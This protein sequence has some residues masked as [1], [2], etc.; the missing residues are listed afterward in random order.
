MNI[1]ET[2]SISYAY[3]KKDRP[4][5]SDLSLKVPKGSIYGFIGINGSGKSTTMRLLTGLLGEENLDVKWFD[6]PLNEQIPSLFSRVGVLIEQPSLYN[7][8]T[9][10]QNLYNLAIVHEVPKQARQEKIN[11]ILELVG[12]S[13]AKD[14]KAG[15]YSLGMRQRLAIAQ[16]LM[17]DPEV[18]L[19]DE[20][21]NGLDSIGIV[22]MRE[23]LLKINRSHEITLVIS[24]HLLEELE[25]ITTHLGILHEGTLK[26]QGT[27]D[28]FY[29]ENPAVS[30][31][32]Q[33]ILK[34]NEK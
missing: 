25:K 28:A 27:M 22:K 10:Y 16:T 4:V 31:I 2:K 26:F 34:I 24:S 33:Y 9:G 29:K 11:D 30:T 21:V 19:L 32:E 1:I 7:H 17:G 20:P 12:L 14:K 18:L 8:L 5:L 6:T 13:D 23:L 3:S 15:A